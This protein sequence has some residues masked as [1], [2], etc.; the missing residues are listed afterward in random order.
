VSAP[1]QDTAYAWEL[2]ALMDAIIA[3]PDYADWARVMRDAGASVGRPDL[4]D[5]FADDAEVM[6]K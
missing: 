6:Q 4:L 5:G 1:E 2:E 3:H